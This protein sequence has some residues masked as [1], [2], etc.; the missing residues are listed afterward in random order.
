MNHEAPASQPDLV[1]PGTPRSRGPLRALLFVALAVLALRA[2][3]A[4][5]LT[6]AALLFIVAFHEWGHFLAARRLKLHTPEFSV[7]LGPVLWSRHDRRRDMTWSLR[8][9]PLGGYVRIAGMGTDEASH[10]PG[11]RSWGSLS[12]LQ[13]IAL[14]FA[15]PLANMVL[16]LFLVTGI[17]MTTGTAD[18]STV[19]VVPLPDSPAAVAGMQRNDVISSLDGAVLSSYDDLADKVG[20]FDPGKPVTVTVLRDGKAVELQVTPQLSGSTPQLGVEFLP[21]TRM[22]SPTALASSATNLTWGMFRASVTGLAQIAESVTAVPARLLS[23]S[24][25]TD[26]ADAPRLVSPI[27]AARLAQDAASKEWYAPLALLASSSMFIGVFNLL[28]IPPLDG[29]HIAIASWEGVMSRIRK[30]RVTVDPAVLAPIVRMVVAF[31]LLLGVS[32][33]LMDIINPITP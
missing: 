23:T 7:G 11:H 32:S 17:L 14:S 3:P 1:Q 21:V 33:I 12:H 16:S 20:R 19:R 9:L 22:P 30:R 8:A 26:T 2:D 5:F 28:P 6:L 4:L 15:G 29:G 24:D 13:R 18:R 25:T 10:R 31:V 27:G